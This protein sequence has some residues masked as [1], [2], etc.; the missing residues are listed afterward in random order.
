MLSLNLRN[1]SCTN[2]EGLKN[3]AC[4]DGLSYLTLKYTSDGK[5]IVLV[6]S[7]CG[8]FSYADLLV[9]QNNRVISGLTIDSAIYDDNTSGEETTF[10]IEE[11]FDI[12][13]KHSKIKQDSEVSSYTEVYKINDSGHIIKSK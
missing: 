1:F 9:I 7:E 4:H 6:Y 2:I 11:N 12:H 10:V 3:Y 5:Y 8:D 13:I